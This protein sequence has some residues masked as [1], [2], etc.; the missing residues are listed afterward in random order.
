M[1]TRPTIKDIAAECGV[2]LSTVSLVLNNN[3]R[4][5]EKTR[6]KVLDTVKKRGYQPN[7]QARGL[8]SK[9]SNILSVVVPQ[10]NSV[11]S[12]V[13]FGQIINGIYEATAESPYKIMLEVA[14]LK[15]IRSYEY[16]NT[17]KG[18]RADGM[19]FIGS[20][21]YDRYLLEFENE[22]Y[23]FVLLNHYFSGAGLNYVSADYRQAGQL[24]AQHLLGLGHRSI[25]IISGTNIQTAQDHV[26]AFK[27]EC[28]SAGIQDGDLP[29]VDG[30]FN[31]E[32]AFKATRDLLT[33]HPHITAVVCGNDKMALGALQ[34][35]ASLGKRVPNDLSIIGMDDIPATR[36]TIPQL[37]T[38]H[39]PLEEVGHAAAEAVMGIFRE[40]TQSIRKFLPVHL[41]E[42]GSTGP[43]ST[44][45]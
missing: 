10:L 27:E 1:S 33:E 6:D 21:L 25:G 30:R 2:S 35:A 11:F 17:L 8:A 28:A 41:V 24:A 36:Y 31:E 45:G 26:E 19:L 5:S 15:Y 39:A 20:S 7:N 43:A 40:Q 32:D 13:Y 12:D 38:I 3:P 22:P 23:P 44:S 37:T 16:M 18:K 9:S 4:I 34:G 29:W 42:R 14:N